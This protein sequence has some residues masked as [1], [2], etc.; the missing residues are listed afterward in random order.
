MNKKIVIGTACA[1][2]LLIVTFAVIVNLFGYLLPW[3]KTEPEVS[4]Y[5][6]IFNE[7]YP[8]DILVLGEEI[9][10]VDDLR[11][12]YSSTLNAEV[13]ETAQNCERQFIVISN[14][15]KSF[16]PTV[17]ELALIAEKLKK[18]L[19]NVYLI[20]NTLD[21]E[22]VEVGILTQPQ[23][24]DYW[25]GYAYI[26]YNDIRHGNGVCCYGFDFND[27]EDNKELISVLLSVMEQNLEASMR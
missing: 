26:A 12:R 10:L 17:D 18:Q 8:T 2:F 25:M 20:G 15:N 4:K 21:S 13:L 5:A 11:Y 23:K 16:C 3:G 1:F 6:K 19:C 7:N 24:E 22:L 9:E 27:E 14:Y